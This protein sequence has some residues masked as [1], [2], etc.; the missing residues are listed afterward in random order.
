MVD[1][2]WLS[3]REFVAAGVFGMLLGTWLGLLSVEI[4]ARREAKIWRRHC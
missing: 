2:A 1:A 4:D 3:W